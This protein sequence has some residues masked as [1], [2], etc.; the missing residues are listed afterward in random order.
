MTMGFALRFPPFQARRSP[1]LNRP[2]DSVKQAK[3]K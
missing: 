1:F 2:S 3:S